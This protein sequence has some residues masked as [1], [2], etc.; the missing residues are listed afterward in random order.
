MKTLRFVLAVLVSAFTFPL[1]AADVP[2]PS[3]VTRT[4]SVEGITEYDLANGLRVLFAPDASKPTTTV[5]TTYM[6]GSRQE[7]Y[8]ETGMAHLLEHLMFKGTPT[9]PMAW[10][11]FTRRGLR[12]NGSTW[13]DRTNYFASM[14]ANEE[15]LEWYLKWSADAMTHSFI[16][17]KDLDSE[18]T[19]VRNEM[20]NN[21]NQPLNA[22]LEKVIAVSY[23]WHSYGKSTIGARADVENVSI[24]RLQAFYRTHYQPDNAVVILTGKFDEAAALKLIADAYRGIPRPTRKLEPT[25]TVDPTQE[26]E[27]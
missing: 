18:M 4:T 10:N 11:E 7:N 19:V 27:R 3:G 20:E 2:L 16:A 25:Y 21:E 17:R 24:E 23:Q 15:N 13:T 5:N 14:A 9:Y 22:L 12:A 6:V 8:G 1:F 26:G